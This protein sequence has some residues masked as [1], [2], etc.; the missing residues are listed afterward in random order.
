MMANNVRN[1]R[2]EYNAEL[3]MSICMRVAQGETLTEITR[4]KTMPTYT[5]V[6]KWRV[7]YPEFE[8]AYENARRIS[9]FALE[10]EAIA[11]ARKLAGP[12][13][14]NAPR[15][16]AMA[17]AMNQLRWSAERRNDKFSPSK[18]TTT[19]IPIQINT[20]LDLGQGGVVP[21]QSDV[22]TIAAMI[23]NAEEVEG[24]VDD[25]DTETETYTG[26]LTVP[27]TPK[28]LIL[29][30]NSDEYREREKKT[31]NAK[32]HKTPTQIAATKAAHQIRANRKAAKNGDPV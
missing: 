13:N 1:T 28:R 21:M 26:E 10:D 7:T 16:S 12:N 22:Y 4:D 15:V 2:L 20:T 11:A 6:L 29:G 5:A 8:E 18:P 9:A 30:K 23:E 24:S 3:A 27:Q 25:T 31:L 32:H 17:H 14:F 19:M